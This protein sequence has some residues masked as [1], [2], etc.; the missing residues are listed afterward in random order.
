M[1]QSRS[2]P[3]CL[4]RVD[5]S[6]FKLGARVRCPYCQS[7][8]QIQPQVGHG[9]ANSAKSDS[10]KKRRQTV[11]RSNQAKGRTRD[12]PRLQVEGYERCEGL[13]KGAMGSIY[14]AYQT[15][16][17]RKVA[18]KILALEHADKKGFVQRFNREAATG[19][20]I[21]HRNVVR[22]YDILTGKS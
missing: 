11:P 18:L 22:V 15:K 8:F 4:R 5:V 12:Y 21:T 19:A 20:R 10:D 3:S 16:L 7:E 2:C 17:R 6:Q 13:A 9:P 1:I 14:K